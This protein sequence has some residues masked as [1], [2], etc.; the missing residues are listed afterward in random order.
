MKED[1]RN[2]LIDIDDV[3]FDWTSG[4]DSWVRK[5][6]NYSGIPISAR[7]DH[8]GAL[9]YEGIY[10]EFNSSEYFKS[11]SLI[12]G[13]KEALEEISKKYNIILLSSCGLDFFKTRKIN[14]ETHLPNIPYQLILLNLHENKDYY[15]NLYDPILYVDDNMHNVTYSADQ[16]CIHT[17]IFHTEFN[18]LFKHYKVKRAYTWQQIIKE[19]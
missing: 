7:P 2:A 15:I 17:Y 6:K 8:I 11:L 14:L 18:K 4:F 1:L 12:K 9:F 3:I 13:V 5:Y 19:I 16:G 10:A